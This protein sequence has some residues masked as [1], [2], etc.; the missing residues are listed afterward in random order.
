[1]AFAG[2]QKQRCGQPLRHGISTGSIGASLQPAS[3]TRQP[4]WPYRQLG[5]QVRVR[6]VR[7]AGFWPGSG[8]GRRGRVRYTGRELPAGRTWRP[9]TCV[10][11][12]MASRTTPWTRWPSRWRPRG[13][14]RSPGRPCGDGVRARRRRVRAPD[15]LGDARRIEPARA[16]GGVDRL[17]SG[18]GVPRPVTSLLPARVRRSGGGG[19]A[20]LR[21]SAARDGE[22]GPYPAVLLRTSRRRR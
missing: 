3:V 1:M 4:D 17:G 22:R 2:L 9:S 14:V 12:N 16:T 11:R 13:L 6:S 21:F 10:S 19:G 7:C 20:Q 15:D 5:W 8:G 18:P